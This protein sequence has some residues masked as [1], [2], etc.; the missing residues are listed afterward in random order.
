MPD[1]AK[2]SMGIWSMNEYMN[3]HNESVRNVFKRDRSLYAEIVV[4]VQNRI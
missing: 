2:F 1:P 3:E 4:T